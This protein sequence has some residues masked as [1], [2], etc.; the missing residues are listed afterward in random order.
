[1]IMMMM[2]KIKGNEDGGDEDNGDGR[3]G[4]E[5]DEERKMK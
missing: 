5:V 4:K 3:K 2:V 1:M